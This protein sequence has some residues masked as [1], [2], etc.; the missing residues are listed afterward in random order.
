MC[1]WTSQSIRS[2]NAVEILFT[3][4]SFASYSVSLI[5]L[6]DVLLVTMVIH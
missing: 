2:I 5:P 3:H 6:I 1:V 4:S